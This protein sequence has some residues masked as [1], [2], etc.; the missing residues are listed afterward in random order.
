VAPTGKAKKIRF[1][2]NQTALCT[3]AVPVAMEA[4]IF[5]KHNLDVELVNFGGSTDQLLEAI[6]SGKADVGIGMILRW[7][8]P[9]EQGFDVKLVAGV[10]GGCSYLVGSRK[11]GISDIL[12]LRGK[13]IGVAD[14]ASPDKNLYEIILQNHGLDPDKDVEWKQYP[15]ELMSM[16]VE[17]GEIQAYVAGDPNVY[18]QVKNS[19]GNLFRVASNATN[20]FAD[21]TCCVLGVRGSLLRE[22][23]VEVAG[24]YAPRS[25]TPADLTEMLKSYPYGEQPIGSD[26]QRQVLLY[27][28][29]LKRAGVL[30]PSTDPQRYVNRITANLLA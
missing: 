25:A 29:E 10:H 23:P 2:W 30:K 28:N 16:A 26:F 5:E 21:R 22:D 17:K 6:G 18:Y 8:K 3:S 19:N 11:A 15:Q 20:E 1:T 4:G 12:S 7:L 14:F 13:T 24:H 9:L 27:A